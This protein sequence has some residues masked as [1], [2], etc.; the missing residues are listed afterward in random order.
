MLHFKNRLM[1]LIGV[2]R[3]LSHRATAF[4]LFYYT[5]KP[6]PGVQLTF[7]LPL[8]T[9]MRFSKT[10]Y[11]L[12]SPAVWQGDIWFH[13][14]MK[15]SQLLVNHGETTLF[16]FFLDTFQS[17]LEILGNGRMRPCC[18]YRASNKSRILSFTIYPQ[19]IIGRRQT[20]KEKGIFTKFLTFDSRTDIPGDNCLHLCSLHLSFHFQAKGAWI[21]LWKRVL[22]SRDIYLQISP[23]DSNIVLI[24]GDFSRLQKCQQPLS[25]AN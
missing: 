24:Q 5:F 11:F 6:Q 18:N 7:W 9:H 23:W 8:Q 14:D 12:Y 4:I 15:C 3:W 10:R 1:L 20:S 22:I 2:V 21:P 16:C 25:T 13:N 17:W 19:A